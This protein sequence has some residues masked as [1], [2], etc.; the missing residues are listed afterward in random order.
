MQTIDP[1]LLR[2]PVEVFVSDHYIRML[3]QN[4]AAH[5][6]HDWWDTS[7]ALHEIFER[8]VIE[9]AE[10]IQK[11]LADSLGIAQTHH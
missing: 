11:R 10:M 2:E 8:L 6:G 4:F 5:F 9:A 1:G 7:P 3:E